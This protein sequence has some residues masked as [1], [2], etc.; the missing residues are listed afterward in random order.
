MS[1]D[2]KAIDGDRGRGFAEMPSQSQRHAPPEPAGLEV[3]RWNGE[4]VALLQL[5][6]AFLP[7]D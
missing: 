2:F 3:E 7:G 4:K 5:S 6:L 1:R